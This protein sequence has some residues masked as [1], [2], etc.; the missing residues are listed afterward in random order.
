MKRFWAFTI[1]FLLLSASMI[2]GSQ[3]AAHATNCDP[4]SGIVYGANS[5]ALFGYAASPPFDALTSCHELGAFNQDLTS[6]GFD[7]VILVL[8]KNVG[9]S[10]TITT[11][12]SGI[13][14]LDVGLECSSWLAY[15]FTGALVASD[16][17]QFPIAFSDGLLTYRTPDYNLLDYCTYVQTIL[18]GECA[19]LKVTGNYSL[20]TNAPSG[21]YS[22]TLHSVTQPGPLSHSVLP[23]STGPKPLSPNKDFSYKNVLNVTAGIPTPVASPSPTNVPVNITPPNFTLSYQS[24]RIIVVFSSASMTAFASR[25]P[26]T[27]LIVRATSQ[28][29]DAYTLPLVYPDKSA[30]SEAFDGVTSG[31][32]NVETAGVNIRGQQGSWSTPQQINI[33]LPSSKPIIPI[34]S[35]AAKTKWI[36]TKGKVVLHLSGLNPKCSNG[37]N[38]KK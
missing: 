35:A 12:F 22:L 34:K 3:S 5:C 29:G 9:P 14:D 17:S 2:V 21:V 33:S 13:I 36:C 4:N 30:Y 26:N 28:S 7:S 19:D 10:A 38:L 37:Y 6:P 27:G 15:K 1:P 11:P 32:W 24:G 20:P 8:E 18:N 16:G 25:S 31:V 23:G